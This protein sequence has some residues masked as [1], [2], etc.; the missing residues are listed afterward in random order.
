MKAKDRPDPFPAKPSDLVINR[1][2]ER[3]DEA[4]RSK[5]R[6][7]LVA[8]LSAIAVNTQ[9]WDLPTIFNTYLPDEGA[10]APAAENGLPWDRKSGGQKISVLGLTMDEAQKNFLTEMLPPDK[11][12]LADHGRFMDYVTELRSVRYRA[13]VIRLLESQKDFQNLAG[14]LRKDTGEED[15]RVLAEFGREDLW[16]AARLAQ[17]I[18]AVVSIKDEKD[19]RVVHNNHAQNIAGLEGVNLIAGV[20]EEVETGAAGRPQGRRPMMGMRNPQGAGRGAAVSGAT[21][22]Y[23]VYSFGMNVRVQYK[24]IP[25]LLRRF[26]TNSW[27]YRIRFANVIPSAVAAAATG[28]GGPSGRRGFQ[29]MPTGTPAGGNAPTGAPGLAPSPTGEP[30]GEVLEAGHYVWIQVQGEGFQFSPLLQTT[31][32]P[33]GAAAPGSAA[34]AR[35]RATPMPARRGGPPDEDQGPPRHV[36]RLG[37][38]RPSGGH[39]HLRRRERLLQEYQLQRPEKRILTSTRKPS[40]GEREKPPP[41]GKPRPITLTL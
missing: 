39:P 8:I 36:S 12:D 22:L 3:L 21:A 18:S 23:K 29:A 32:K 27:R 4:L 20:G 25:I 13:D 30:E 28:G 9:D 37:H 40:S 34:P 11:E 24:R 14:S 41:P 6:T 15:A 5:S 26:L 19:Y 38:S 10:G 33:A 16:T 31:E 35:P 1:S 2:P 17:A 7:Q